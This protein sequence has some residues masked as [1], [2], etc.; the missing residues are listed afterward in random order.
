MQLYDPR[1]GFARILITHWSEIR[2]SGALVPLETDIDLRELQRVLPSLTIMDIR[3]P[4]AL[5]VAVMGRERRARY[6]T[7]VTGG[8]WYDFI[9]PEA[10]ATAKAIIELLIATPCGVYYRYGITAAKGAVFA[11][12]ALVLP[13]RTAQ[14]D[15][16]TASISVAHVEDGGK[17]VYPLKLDS[18]S[19]DFI[20][21]GAGVPPT[22][23]TGA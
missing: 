20:D 13:M 8:R 9:P 2:R 23:P 18:L 12:E 1:L 4:A 5:M 10:V 15:K 16:P 14:S 6:P 3:E 7:E 22:P 17:M 11:G 19:F 21:I